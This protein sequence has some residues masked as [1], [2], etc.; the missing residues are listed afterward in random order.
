MK[1]HLEPS[2]LIHIGREII[3]PEQ[4]DAAA[5]AIQESELAERTIHADIIKAEI[6][7]IGDC[8]VLHVS[9]RVKLDDLDHVQKLH[10]P[11]PHRFTA[12]RIM[13]GCNIPVEDL[14]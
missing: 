9:V 5:Q 12:D 11:L 2:G 10:Y 6:T 3:T 4:A 13:A 7:A 14:R 1:Q 8:A